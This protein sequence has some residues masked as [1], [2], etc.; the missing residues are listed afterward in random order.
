MKKSR[1]AVIV[2]I[3]AGLLAVP[4]RAQVIPGRWEKVAVLSF[5]TPITVDLKNGDR[6]QGKSEELSPSELFLRTHS[7]QAVIPKSEIQRVTT[8]EPDSR[9][10]GTLIGA[11]IGMIVTLPPKTSPV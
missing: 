7:A 8:L 4:A 10:N 5:G 1:T 2:L 11:G 6:I 3:L 9:A